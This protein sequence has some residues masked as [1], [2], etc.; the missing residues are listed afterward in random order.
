LVSNQS[1]VDYI[2]SDEAKMSEAVLPPS[3][4]PNREDL[5]VQKLQTEVEQL[6]YQLEQSRLPVWKNWRVLGP[7]AGFLVSVIG[8]VA[9]YNS[10]QDELALQRQQFNSANSKIS[11]ENVKLR[12]EN[13]SMQQRIRIVANIEKLKPSYFDELEK[14]KRDVATWDR[15]VFQNR[16]ELELARSKE[17]GFEFDADKKNGPLHL[18]AKQNVA[19]LERSLEMRRTELDASRGRQR[20]LEQILFKSN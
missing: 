13:E 18:A 19:L 6:R 1:L 10:K 15:A 12:T 4:A 7:V 11:E 5:E 3:R 2:S 16:M 9:Q 17:Q 8:N 20:E 14:V